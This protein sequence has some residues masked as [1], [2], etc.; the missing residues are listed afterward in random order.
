MLSKDEFYKDKNSG[1]FCLSFKDGS[2][3]L[4]GLEQGPLKFL[5]PKLNKVNPN[6]QNIHLKLVD[7][8][9]YSYLFLGK[10]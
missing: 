5:K 3:L 9:E 10:L 4:T 8:C 2:L 1:L 7:Y 6:A